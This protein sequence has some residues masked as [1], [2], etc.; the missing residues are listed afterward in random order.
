MGNDSS[1][2]RWWRRRTRRRRR[3]RRSSQGSNHALVQGSTAAIS[4]VRPIY[5]VEK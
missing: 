1:S 5:Y 4:L 2:G 3:K